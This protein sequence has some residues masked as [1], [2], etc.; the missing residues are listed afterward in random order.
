MN[1]IR[2]AVVFTIALTC[3]AGLAYG[4][5]N[6]LQQVPTRTIEVPTRPVVVATTN[7]ALGTELRADDLTVTAWPEAWPWCTLVNGQFYVE[8]EDTAPL[9]DQQGG[10]YLTY[11]RP[12]YVKTLFPEAEILPPPH[13]EY[14]QW[15]CVLRQSPLASTAAADRH[16]GA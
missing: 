16:G 10:Y 4:T 13:P 7:L 3:G 2:I 8:P 6:Y 5:Y 14:R 12:D 9:R 15:G 1:R 11:Y